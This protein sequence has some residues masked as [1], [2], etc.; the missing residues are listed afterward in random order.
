ME[1]LSYLDFLKKHGVGNPFS[2]DTTTDDFPD[3]QS[4]V[5]SSDAIGD[6][7]FVLCRRHAPN[8]SYTKYNQACDKPTYPM[9]S[10]F[11]SCGDGMFVDTST[12]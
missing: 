2:D 8:S 6:D 7:Y 10:K 3:C 12:K 1:I 11:S 9:V 5:Y 4:C